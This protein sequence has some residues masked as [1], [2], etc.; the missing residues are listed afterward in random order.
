MSL[1]CLISTCDMLLE[2]KDLISHFSGHVTDNDKETLQEMVD[3]EAEIMALLGDARLEEAQLILLKAKA[4]LGDPVSRI[5]LKEVLARRKQEREKE[6]AERQ[7]AK[8]QAAKDKAEREAR[9]RAKIAEQEAKEAAEDIEMAP[10]LSPT[11]HGKASRVSDEKKD[12]YEHKQA[13]YN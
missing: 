6:A 5:A 7:A 13:H 9:N 12:E 10:A 11:I 3:K 2:D 1:T 4:A 8:E